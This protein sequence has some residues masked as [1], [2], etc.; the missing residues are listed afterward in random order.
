LEELQG[1]LSEALFSG[2]ITFD[3]NEE[4]V[5]TP[6]GRRIPFSILSSG[7]L[8]LLPLWLTLNQFFDGDSA[9]HFVYIEEPEAHLFP[10]TQGILTEYLVKL[11]GTSSSQ[12]M[13]ITT[14]SPYILGKINNLLKAGSLSENKSR[15]DQLKIEKVIPKS[16]WLK[17]KDVTA[18]AIIDRRVD[19]I[20]G[21]DGLIDGEYLD[22]VSGEISRAFNELLEIE[23]AE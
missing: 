10:S 22:D 18:Y 5:D 3:K 9:N 17:T 21:D 1:G 2:S 11:L 12:K 8:E 23:Y 20:T 14:H 19:R 6:D 7:Q 16:A 13:L 15:R 4:Y